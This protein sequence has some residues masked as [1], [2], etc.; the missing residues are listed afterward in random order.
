[1]EIILQFISIFFDSILNTYF[2]CIIGEYLAERKFSHKNIFIFFITMLI[3]SPI[4][5]YLKPN[6]VLISIIIFVAVVLLNLLFNLKLKISHSLSLIVTTFLLFSLIESI[7]AFL[8]ISI[9]GL[10]AEQ[11]TNNPILYFSLT[12]CQFLFIFLV[13]LLMKYIKKH[14]SNF[15]YLMIA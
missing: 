3:S 15:D 8:F 10:N 5:R 9:S 13:I 4:I 11:I 12:I 1:M 2:M 6:F 14:I 7:T